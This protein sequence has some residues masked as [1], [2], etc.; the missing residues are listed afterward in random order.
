MLPRI[1]Y[2]TVRMS[3]LFNDFD[4]LFN[5]FFGSWPTLTKPPMDKFPIIDP[6][7]DDDVLKGWSIQLAL[8]GYDESDIKVWNEADKLHI[9]ADNTSRENISEKFRSKFHHEIKVYR[10]LDLENSKVSFNNGILDIS[11]PV[12]R[13][14]TNKKLLFGKD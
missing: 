9:M 13:F 11:I 10:D 1:V 14:E 3:S 5:D 4:C 12:K 6:D 7:S 2:P 8:A